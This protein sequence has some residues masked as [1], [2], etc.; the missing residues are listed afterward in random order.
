M[1]LWEFLAFIFPIFS[2]LLIEVCQKEYVLSCG[3][4]P[5]IM[6]FIL[7]FL[8]FWWFHLKYLLNHFDLCCS[9]WRSMCPRLSTKQFQGR[10]HQYPNRVYVQ[11]SGLVSS[12]VNL[13][14]WGEVA[15]LALVGHFSS[16]GVTIKIPYWVYVLQQ[17]PALHPVFLTGL[18][19]TESDFIVRS[20][21][22][23]LG[24]WTL[25][26]VL[27]SVDAYT[28][29]VFANVT[30]HLE[31]TGIGVFWLQCATR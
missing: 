10:H 9:A 29:L 20:V 6:V 5:V 30:H 15:Y 19:K 14:S 26:V 16:D 31:D 23:G 17:W 22:S 25:V 21:E 24:R 8:I 27:I 18:V 4:M 28:F 11:N 13:I 2:V 7:G 12:G 3:N 1:Y